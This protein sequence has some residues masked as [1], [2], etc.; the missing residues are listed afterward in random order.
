M[1]LSRI[2]SQVEIKVDRLGEIRDQTGPGCSVA[3][4]GCQWLPCATDCSVFRM[5]QMISEAC[6]MMLDACL[7]SIP[8]NSSPMCD[9]N[10]LPAPAT[11]IP[12]GY[13]SHHPSL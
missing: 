4:C 9:G 8:W 7:S 3:H 5:L 6:W 10:M 2:G 11:L 12:F 13:V 1:V